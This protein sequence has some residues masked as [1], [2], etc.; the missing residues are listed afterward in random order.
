MKSYYFLSVTVPSY[1]VGQDTERDGSGDTGNPQSQP[2]PKSQ[3]TGKPVRHTQP[4]GDRRC[5]T[6]QNSG[7]S[8]CQ[9]PLHFLLLERQQ[10]ES[11]KVS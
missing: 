6:G 10:E 5:H 9:M 1:I 11:P 2:T 4:K 7:L 3:N 8:K